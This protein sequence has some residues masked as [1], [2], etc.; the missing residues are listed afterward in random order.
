MY[1][2]LSLLTSMLF[3]ITPFPLTTETICRFFR[4]ITMDNV[5][6]IML[7]YGLSRLHCNARGNGQSAAL[8]LGNHPRWWTPTL[9]QLSSA[10][11]HNHDIYRQP[12]AVSQAMGIMPDKVK[13]PFTLSKRD[14]ESCSTPYATSQ[15]TRTS[16]SERARIPDFKGSTLR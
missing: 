9:D 7:P 12:P 10:S 15:A 5:Y 8:P 16:P 13:K 14:R 1:F 3:P 4:S 11:H 2:R 6:P